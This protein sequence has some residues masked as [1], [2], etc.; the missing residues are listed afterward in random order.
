MRKP[1]DYHKFWSLCGYAADVIQRSQAVCQLCGWDASD[2]HLWRQLTVE[3]VIGKSQGGYL[4]DIRTAVAERFPEIE[5]T[6]R[7]EL[8]QKLESEN[9][10]AACQSCNSMTSRMRHTKDMGQLLT[11]AT[12]TPG[13]VVEKV[14]AEIQQVLK[15]KREDVEWK[16]TSVRERFDTHIAP[17]LTGRLNGEAANI[18]TGS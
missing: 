15:N 6:K 10:V 2:F 8:V 4:K 16:L 11:E 3:H 7:D 1:Y 17:M 12:G 5:D 14:I 18:G 13:E 9:T